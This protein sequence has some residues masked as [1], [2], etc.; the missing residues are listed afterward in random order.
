[1]RWEDR[2]K[3]A[4]DM[5]QATIMPTFFKTRSDAHFKTFEGDAYGDFVGYALR[6]YK[7]DEF[8]LLQLLLAR[9]VARDSI[10]RWLRRIRKEFATF[11]VCE[12][13]F[14]MT[15]LWK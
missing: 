15:C 12:Q 13:K 14:Q 5:K 2:S 7:N 9:Q 1:M 3:L 10:G 8:P 4:C 11:P 6:F